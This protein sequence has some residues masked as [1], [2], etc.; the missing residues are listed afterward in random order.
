MVRKFSIKRKHMI[1]RTKAKRGFRRTK[2]LVRKS[3]SRSESR[4]QMKSLVGGGG[5][6]STGRRCVDVS[7][8]VL[9][10]K[11]GKQWQYTWNDGK[12]STQSYAVDG[13]IKNEVI[14]NNIESL[15]D[16]VVTNLKSIIDNMDSEDNIIAVFEQLR[17]V[18]IHQYIEFR[19]LTM[20]SLLYILNKPFDHTTMGF[21]IQYKLAWWLIEHGA[22]VNYSALQPGSHKLNFFTILGN[23]IRLLTNLSSTKIMNIP[24]KLNVFNLTKFYNIVYTLVLLLS[25]GASMEF[26]IHNMN[27]EYDLKGP[28]VTTSPLQMLREKGVQWMTQM[29][30]LSGKIVSMSKS[31]VVDS[32]SQDAFDKESQDAFDEVMGLEAKT[33]SLIKIFIILKEPFDGVLDLI[34][35]PSSSPQDKTLLT[36]LEQSCQRAMENVH[37]SPAYSVTDSI[38]KSRLSELQLGQDSDRD[39][40]PQREQD[41]DVTWFYVSDDSKK[42]KAYLPEI[43]L[44][45][46]EAASREYTILERLQGGVLYKFTP[47]GKST[48]EWIFNFAAMTQTNAVTMSGRPIQRGKVKWEWENDLGDSFKPFEPQVAQL[49]EKAYNQDEPIVDHTSTSTSTSIRWKFDLNTMTQTNIGTNGQRNIKRTI[50]PVYS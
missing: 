16:H 14:A 43:V 10:F 46:E 40:D 30:E 18:I 31:F 49:L 11:R 5:A 34:S 29:K 25:R 19:R 27:T 17:I 38:K 28:I 44:F 24:N 13:N 47:P 8:P 12:L 37:I 48:V 50:V 35:Q 42:I 32:D 39:Q 45:L 1:R 36:A 15:R 3:R 22:D 2:K 23:V 33:N 21:D 26:Q 6:C 20:S 41:R 7:S 9:T 4:S